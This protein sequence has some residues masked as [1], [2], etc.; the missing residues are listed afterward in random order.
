MLQL[1]STEKLSVHL[2]LYFYCYLNISKDINCPDTLQNHKFQGVVS[3]LRFGN[4]TIPFYLRVRLAKKC[5]QT[6]MTRID[7]VNQTHTAC[8]Q[9][10]PDSGEQR[11]I[12]F[13][14]SVVPLLSACRPAAVRAAEAMVGPD[15]GPDWEK[16]SGRLG[17]SRSFLVSCVGGQ[18]TRERVP[19][20]A[21]VANKP[22]P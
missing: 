8:G 9:C 3:P 16:T 6:R 19:V 22:W 15:T 11:L 5:N 1:L 2:I 17:F 18:E 14:S 20:S 4:E 10:S 21:C 12:G 13:L 7:L